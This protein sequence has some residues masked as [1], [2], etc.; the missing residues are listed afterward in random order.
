[1]HGREEL[2]RIIKPPVCVFDRT[3]ALI[4]AKRRARVRCAR[5]TRKSARN[6]ATRDVRIVFCKPP[7]PQ[8]GRIVIE[9]RGK[10]VPNRGGGKTEPPRAV[11]RS[12]SRI[13]RRRLNGAAGRGG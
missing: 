12:R 3:P 13:A 7:K 9:R 8:R 10:T 5:S 1:M 2:D 11:I 6:T 4:D